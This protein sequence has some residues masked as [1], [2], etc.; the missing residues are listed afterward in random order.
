MSVHVNPSLNSEDGT[1]PKTVSVSFVAKEHVPGERT[2]YLELDFGEGIPT[3]MI[4]LAKG[5]S[6]EDAARFIASAKIK[7]P[8]RRRASVRA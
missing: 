6:I 2:I 7:T 1:L 3:K 8:S 4:Y 5:F